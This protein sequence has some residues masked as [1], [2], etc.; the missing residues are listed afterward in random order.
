[1]RVFLAGEGRTELGEWAKQPPYREQPG[2]K[3]VLVALIERVA[4][5]AA[6]FVDGL[7]WSK[8]RKYK[9]G[10]HASPEERNVL[11]LA[12]SARRARCDV[13]VFTRDRDGSA[14]R[15]R[16]LD[17]G[18]RRARELFAD[19][20][21]V[22]GVA[23]ENVEGWVLVL[24][25]FHTGERVSSKKTKREL[26]TRFGIT[27]VQQMVDAVASAPL[28]EPAPGSL[29]AWLG[30]ARSVFSRSGSDVGA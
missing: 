30:L 3:G 25:G 15:Q 22:G 12:L 27:T 6:T 7:L 10:N 19:L 29:S 9:A 14:G 24:L 20:K 11:G 18:I 2:E 23:I 1:M 17:A 13:V 26:E 28:D 8:I 21:M 16:D 5:D 4:D